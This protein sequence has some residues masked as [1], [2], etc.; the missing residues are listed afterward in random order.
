MRQPPSLDLTFRV[1]FSHPQQ[2]LLQFQR[3]LAMINTFP[4]LGFSIFPEN[5]AG[6]CLHDSFSCSS[7]ALRKLVF[8][9]QKFPFLQNER[10]N[11][12][13]REWEEGMGEDKWR[14]RRR[15]G[16]AV[17]C[18]HTEADLF[19]KTQRPETTLS[20]TDSQTQSCRWSPFVKL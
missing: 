6:Q 15:K 14:R 8:L 7:S 19:Q 1:R 20:K 17:T 4:A 12:R 2:D 10:T 5:S 9:R 3:V 16:E 11:G 18:R 13:G